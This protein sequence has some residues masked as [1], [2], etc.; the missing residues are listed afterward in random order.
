MTRTSTDEDRALKARHRTMW[1]LGDYP[2]VVADLISSLG[3]ALTDACGVTAGQRVL[4]VAAGTGNAA[5]PAALAGADVVADRPQRGDVVVDVGLKSEGLIPKDEF[6]DP[7]KI[8]IG[9]QVTV[10]LE[11][12]EGEGGTVQLSKRKADRQRRLEQ[13]ALA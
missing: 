3:P 6:D 2:A 12:I 13:A 7:S 9:E 10:V 11:S 1:A 5:I 4:D 8:K